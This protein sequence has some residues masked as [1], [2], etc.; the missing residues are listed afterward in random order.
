MHVISEIHAKDYD[1][2]FDSI[3]FKYIEVNDDSLLV[4]KPQN[5]KDPSYGNVT[6][7]DTTDTYFVSNNYRSSIY[8]T[9][10]IQKYL[11]AIK[12]AKSEGWNESKQDSLNNK[13][14]NLFVLSKDK[15]VLQFHKLPDDFNEL[16]YF[17][18]LGKT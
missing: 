3:G 1:L 7:Q 14:S 9:Y 15:Y 12:D 17:I 6:V 10:D 16:Q 2:F 4:F 11:S 13:K 5:W 8:I 18:L